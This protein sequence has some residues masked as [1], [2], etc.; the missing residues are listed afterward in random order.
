MRAA[1]AGSVDGTWALML[2]GPRLS[3][4][5]HMLEKEAPGKGGK[6]LNRRSIHP[7]GSV[8]GRHLGETGSEVKGEW[9]K[10]R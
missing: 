3:K 8:A 9:V 4:R 6:S 5:P 1:F 2:S 10:A 7:K